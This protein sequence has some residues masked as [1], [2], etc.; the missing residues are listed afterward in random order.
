[1]YSVRELKKVITLFKKKE[2]NRQKKVCQAGL[3]SK[4]VPVCKQR[5]LRPVSIT[6]LKLL[7]IVYVT[8]CRYFYEFIPSPFLGQ[9]LT[10]S[11]TLI[12]IDNFAG[13]G[14]FNNW[15]LWVITPRLNYNLTMGDF[16]YV[17][18]F[19]ET[20]LSLTA[21]YLKRNILH[22]FVCMISI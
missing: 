12:F 14:R 9:H 10:L 22:A 2:G 15:P 6:R 19:Y 16:I 8:F 21:Q 11:G 13:L 3:G 5:I 18:L 17:S 20:L 7:L 4:L 1:M